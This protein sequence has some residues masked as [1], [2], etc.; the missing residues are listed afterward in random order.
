MRIMSQE[1][2]THMLKWSRKQTIW[3]DN[4]ESEQMM[5]A[6]AEE[7]SLKYESEKDERKRNQNKNANHQDK[8]QT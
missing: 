2:F 5:A 4:Y 8:R 6:Y 3:L 7:F 1:A